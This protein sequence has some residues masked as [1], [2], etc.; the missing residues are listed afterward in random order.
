MFINFVLVHTEDDNILIAYFVLDFNVGTVKCCQGNSTSHHEF[1]VWGTRCFFRSQWDLFRD[2][3]CWNDKFRKADTVVFKEDHFKFSLEAFIIV[4]KIGNFVDKFDNRFSEVITRGSFGTKDEYTRY[5]VFIWIIFQ[6]PIKFD[7]V[8]KVKQLTFVSVKTF[9]LNIKDSICRHFYACCFFDVVCQTL[10]SS[11]LNLIELV[12]DFL[13]IQV[14]CKIFKLMDVVTPT[15]TNHVI[16]GCWKFRSCNLCPTTLNDTICLVIEFFR[17]N[18][19]EIVKCIFFKKFG[20]KF[21]N[22]VNWVTTDDSQV[23]H[24]N[25]TILNDTST[26]DNIRSNTTSSHFSNVTVVDFQDDLVNT[27][28]DTFEELLIPFFKGFLKNSVVSVAHSLNS[29]IPSIFPWKTIFIKEKTHE[30]SWCNRRVGIIDVNRY[31]FVDI[32]QW[33]AHL[34]VRFDDC[35]ETGTCHKV[36][37]NQTQFFTF[38]C[39]IIW[40]KNGSNI[41]HTTA[42]FQCWVIQLIF[43]RNFNIPKAKIVNHTIFITN[44]R[45]IIR[46]GTKDLSILISWDKATI[47]I[48]FKN[49]ITKEFHI[50]NIVVFTCFPNITCRTKP[51]IW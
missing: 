19:I 25:L 12:Q 38:N 13:V 16:N 24:M 27:W 36:L 41:F 5:H 6:I 31:F 18:S 51:T 26:F 37:L 15:I 42:C 17:I 35:L 29:R 39:W 10:F 3:C 2:I 9:H 33:Q 40:I 44:L 23:S 4:N 32:F 50:D 22:P 48:A 47:F 45:H 49:Y 1:H 43:F 46:Y 28:K 30:F 7:D 11:L 14:S 20:M 8:E 21:G 34:E